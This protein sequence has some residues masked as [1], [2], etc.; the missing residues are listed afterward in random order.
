MPL[1]GP[2]TFT[3]G[4]TPMSGAS[5]PRSPTAAASDLCSKA[6]RVS[7]PGGANSYSGGTTLNAGTLGVCNNTAL[8]SS[9]LTFTTP[10]S[11]RFGSGGHAANNILLD[12]NATFAAT[13]SNAALP[14]AISDGGAGLSLTMAGPGTLSLTGNNIYSGGTNLNG[15]ALS[16]ASESSLGSGGLNF[17][18]G[19]LQ[20]AAG[21][22]DSRA[23]TLNNGGGTINTGSSASTF[24]GDI[25]RRRKP[26]HDR[27]RIPLCH[28]P[29][30]QLPR[31]DQPQRRQC[32]QRRSTNATSARSGLTFAGG[33]LQSS[34]PR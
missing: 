5:T 8:G 9:L 34:E 16:I 29:Q 21:L 30:Q 3:N 6:G 25:Q 7:S 17:N 1:D 14:G 12:A 22:T 2:V 31:R 4:S 13:G 33:T 32:W 28:Q 23:V 11:C 20:T 27:E 26:D 19:T 18:G 24:S 15:G 10:A